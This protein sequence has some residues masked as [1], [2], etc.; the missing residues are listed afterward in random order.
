MRRTY[1]LCLSLT[2]LEVL[3]GKAALAA[4][5]TA[6]FNVQIIIASECKVQST[7]T[8]NFGSDGVLDA[9]NDATTTLGIQ[10]TQNTAYTVGLSAGVG[11]GATVAA[12]KMTGSGV[13]TVTYS[14]YRDAGRTLVWGTTIGTDTVAGTGNG[15]VQSVTVYGRV[16]PQTTPPPDTYVDTITATVTY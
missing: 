12:R 3:A 10:C 16:P 9:N 14:L 13:P 7:A 2:V 6:T 4:T 5:A 11:S 1:L 8:L 15:A